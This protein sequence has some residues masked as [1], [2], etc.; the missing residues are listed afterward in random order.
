VAQ[1]VRVLQGTAQVPLERVAEADNVQLM[2]S[3]V[4]RGLGVGVLSRLDVE[5]EVAAGDLA[6]TPISDPVLKPLT[7]ALCT[8]TARTP[9][10]AADMVLGEIQQAFGAWNAGL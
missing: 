5:S 9:S 6:F 7:L 2:I 8:A 3:L 1:Q 10:L 4:R